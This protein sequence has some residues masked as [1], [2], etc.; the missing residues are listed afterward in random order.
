[1]KKKKNV[2]S[3][4]TIKTTEETVTTKPVEVVEE[5]KIETVK[6]VTIVK[7]PEKKIINAVSVVVYN[8]RSNDAKLLLEQLTF[9]KTKYYP[10]T[11]IITV[12]EDTANLLDLTKGQFIVHIK[13]P[14]IIAKDFLHQ[15]YINMR[16]GKDS[17]E[18]NGITCVNRKTLK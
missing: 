1:M 5:T 9:Q 16:S 14:K 12:E 4:T 17:Y 13:E 6:P 15:L 2:F 3:K 8:N 7:K 11:E 10:E 18:V